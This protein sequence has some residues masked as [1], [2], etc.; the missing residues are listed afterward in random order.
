MNDLKTPVARLLRLARSARDGWKDKAL[1]RQQR[2]R[3]AQVR[4]RD[5]EHSRSY[6][7]TRALAA[8][9]GASERA[10]ADGGDGED[11]DEES[12]P[13]RRRCRRG[14]PTTAIAWR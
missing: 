13:W 3:A 9:G 5:L 2:L 10:A 6:W 12:P 14:S 11:G 4:I 7:K 1:E 8:E